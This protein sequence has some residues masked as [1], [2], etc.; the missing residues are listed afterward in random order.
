MR[1]ARE[2]LGALGATMGR[3]REIVV[4]PGNHDHA[5]V[6]PF[7]R[8]LRGSGRRLGP[9]TRVPVSSSAGLT[10]LAA[11]LR[12]ARVRVHYPGVNLGDGVHAHHG[13][14]VDR[15]LLPRARGVLARGPLAPVPERGATPMDYER[16]G[17]TRELP[18]P[19]DRAA[20]G[21]RLATA[22]VLPLAGRLMRTGA[23]APLSAAALGVQFRRA[24][25][26]AMEAVARGLGLRARHVV[27]GHL[28]RLG[29]LAGDDVSEWTVADGRIRLHN[30]GSWVHEPLLLTGVTPPHP[31]WPGG[32]VLLEPGAAPRALNLLGDV[33]PAALA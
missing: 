25:L 12:P 31:Y 22:T 17:P 28:H 7:L 5:L 16:A 20:G 14:Y 26:P 10:A 29:P 19:V 1:V 15:H 32:A 9:A 3:G 33:T 13:H 30:T 11:A 8:G 4:V 18:E 27:F 24:G 2:P 23:I 21:L 6:R